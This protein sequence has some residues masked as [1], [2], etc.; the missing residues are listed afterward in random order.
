MY[1]SSISLKRQIEVMYLTSISLKLFQKHLKIVPAQSLHTM[2][3]WQRK[4]SS[5]L[6]HLVGAPWGTLLRNKA[7]QIEVMYLTSISLKLW[8][9]L[10]NRSSTKSA[11]N[12]VLTRKIFQPVGSPCKSPLGH[13]A[14]KQR[15]TDSSDVPEFHLSK[16]I[17]HTVIFPEQS[18]QWIEIAGNDK[19]E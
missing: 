2:K 13:I 18:K 6:V 5:Q 12:E 7:R 11:Y 4:Y 3:Y 10:K 17:K 15:T 9:T 19:I 1:L 8:K 14:K 16:T